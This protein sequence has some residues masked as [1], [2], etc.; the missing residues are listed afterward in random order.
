M[1]KEIQMLNTK[2]Q[3]KALIYCRV[4][5]RKQKEEGHGIASQEISCEKYCNQKGY[6][7]IE[8]Y[9][10]EAYSGNQKVRPAL[11]ALLNRLQNSNENYVV[12][13]DDLNR[14]SRN[15][16]DGISF[17]T[18]VKNLGGRLESVKEVIEDTPIGKFHVTLQF[19]FGQLHLEQNR[20]QVKSRMEAQLSRGRRVY[21]RPSS[22]YQKGMI[23]Y[24]PNA[25]IARQVYQ[26]LVSGELPR[27]ASALRDFIEAKGFQEKKS[28]RPI[29]PSTHV[30]E[31]MLGEHVI[32]ESAGYVKYEGKWIEGEHEA[33]ISQELAQQVINCLN[34][35][36]NKA[37]RANLHE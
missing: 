22:W 30:I 7:V 2:N 36:G 31:S 33:I 32:M 26:R 29:R 6:K 35:T 17:M 27:N 13:V 5:S 37:Y 4:S 21:G 24:E 1:V 18:D 14:W 19:A 3:T 9:K 12:V 15:V 25:S 23:P 8:C 28:G 16:V 20:I 11:I 10:D 34:G